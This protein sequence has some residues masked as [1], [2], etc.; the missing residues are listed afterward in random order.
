MITALVLTVSS[1]EVEA[2]PPTIH[3]DRPKVKV[4]LNVSY[5]VP[6]REFVEMAGRTKTFVDNCQTV[7]SVVLL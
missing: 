4:L 6:Q 2:S 5:F 7:E 1:D 3:S